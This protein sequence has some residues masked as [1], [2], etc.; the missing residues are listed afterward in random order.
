M[1]CV[2]VSNCWRFA[3]LFTSL[4]S[5]LPAL[6]NKLLRL[7]ENHLLQSIV[8][9]VEC[10]Y[11][12]LWCSILK[13]Q[14]TALTCSTHSIDSMLG[15]CKKPQMLVVVVVPPSQAEAGSAAPAVSSESLKHYVLQP[16]CAGRKRA[17]AAKL[18]E[19]ALKAHST[20]DQTQVHESADL[21]PPAATTAAAAATSSAGISDR[22]LPNIEP[23]V[24]AD[25]FSAAGQA[26]SKQSPGE[27]GA[28]A[29]K[30][31]QQG[32][33]EV[34]Q[35]HSA[36]EDRSQSHGLELPLS[37]LLNGGP[38]K[39]RGRPYKNA[40]NAEKAAQRDARKA[41]QA[42][43]E[44]AAYQ[45]AGEAAQ[46]VIAAPLLKKRRG[47][48]PKDPAKLAAAL[49]AYQA[50]A[51][52]RQAASTDQE[53]QG[54]PGFGFDTVMEAAQAAAAHASAAAAGPSAAVA[55]PAQQLSP[56]QTDVTVTAPAPRSG[57]KKRGRPPKSI[58]KALG[59]NLQSLSGSAANGE[60]HSAGRQETM[61]AT[62]NDVAEDEDD[63]Q[64]LLDAAAVL[65]S[66]LPFPQ[67]IR[68]QAL[69]LQQSKRRQPK[70]RHRS[71][72]HAKVQSK[73][74]AAAQGKQRR[75]GLELVSSRATAL[76]DSIGPDPNGP[77][78]D[79]VL[80]P[81]PHPSGSPQIQGG[82]PPTSS[83]LERPAP[84]VSGHPLKKQRKHHHSSQQPATAAAGST[85]DSPQATPA[86]VPSPPSP[87]L[88]EAMNDIAHTDDS[89]AV[90]V[91]TAAVSSPGVHDAGG[92][93]TPHATPMPTVP[94]SVAGELALHRV[95]VS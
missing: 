17:E 4:I 21:F 53:Q 32:Q 36:T 6:L 15:S 27:T 19:A 73:P 92:L 94:H 14:F 60:D 82:S 66:D 57:Q 93:P 12:A 41:A 74:A 65:T 68:R 23:V 9:W 56:P 95:Q 18:A 51:H 86:H 52:A 79:Q 64:A 8:P 28:K 88:P 2:H 91:P 81:Q 30:P 35:T 5:G 16:G 22:S 7:T 62:A 55:R 26:T 54:N 61:S 49:A 42:A 78:R 63:D 11:L 75:R 34:L 71:G 90:A 48:P 3:V 39:R 89:S 33:E 58:A 31:T 44:K 80:S 29:E 45:A 24:H 40:A 25:T 87:G 1:C 83:H 76:L 47:R 20:A 85:G 37:I 10:M 67:G 69:P 43:V 84:P 50:N 72:S 38:V 70:G 59:D 77:A 13:M 46:V